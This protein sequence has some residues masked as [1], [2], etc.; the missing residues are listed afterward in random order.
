[1]K[2]HNTNTKQFMS[3]IN[4]KNR[5]SSWTNGFRLLSAER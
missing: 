4:S 3:A 5:Q 2:K 1:M